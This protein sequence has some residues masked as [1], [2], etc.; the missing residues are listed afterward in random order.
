MVFDCETD[1][2]ARGL[3]RLEAETG[4]DVSEQLSIPKADGL[5]E[6]TRVLLT[7]LSQE[8]PAGKWEQ[9][10]SDKND[11]VRLDLVMIAGASHG[12]TTAARFAKEVRCG[13]VVMLCGPRDQDQDWQSIPSATPAE[14]FFGFTHVLDEG[15]IGHHHCGSWEML[16]LPCKPLYLAD[17]TLIASSTNQLP[18]DDCGS[19][20][21]R[22]ILIRRSTACQSAVDRP[23]LSHSPVNPLSCAKQAFLQSFPF[24]C[25]WAWHRWLPPVK[26]R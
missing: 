10:L 9:L 7:W 22:A 20:D 13:R 21:D 26:Y 15:W 17:Q 4:R 6:R 12:A 25:G 19:A 23:I 1:R 2:L 18:C 8:I 11:A 3:V 5:M 24:L 16:G 14:R